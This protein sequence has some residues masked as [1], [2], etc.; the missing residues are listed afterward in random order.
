MRRPLTFALCLL[1][2]G[3]C[4]IGGLLLAAGGAI[5]RAEV[6]LAVASVLFCVALRIY[7]TT[8]PEGG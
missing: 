8:P 6:L 2:G 4:V 7:A 1:L 5:W 3:W